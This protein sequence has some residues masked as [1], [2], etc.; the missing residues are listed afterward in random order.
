MGQIYKIKKWY[1]T[2]YVT[3]MQFI[4]YKQKWRETIKKLEWN[5][6]QLSKDAYKP[7]VKYPK[8]DGGE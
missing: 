8:K 5:P 6:S 7:V 1:K 3:P 2:C 4:E